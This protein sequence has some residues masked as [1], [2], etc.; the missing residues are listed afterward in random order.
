MNT[1]Y[2][3][4]FYRYVRKKWKKLMKKLKK[5]NCNT[6]STIDSLYI[7]KFDKCHKR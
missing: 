5:K 4:I 6:I 3:L 2:Y 1:K 7:I